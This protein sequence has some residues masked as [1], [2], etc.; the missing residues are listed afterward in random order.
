MLLMQQ[1]FLLPFIKAA[2]S[3][4]YTLLMLVFLSFA[5]AGCLSSKDRLY[6]KLSKEDSSNIKYKGHYKIGQEYKVKGNTYTPEKN[7]K[8][9]EVGIASWYGS[10]NGLHGK[11]TANGD[12]YNKY[13][14]SAAHPTLPL[15]CL[16]KV[17]NLKNNKSLIVMVNDRGPFS[18][19]RILDVSEQA[20]NILGFKT[21]GTTKVRVRYLDKETKEFYK[22]INLKPKTG[23]KARSKV[24]NAKCS[25]NCHVKLINLKHNLQVTPQQA[26]K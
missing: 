10:K 25:V 9:D 14:L 2:S 21:A 20:A 23:A 8:Y 15:P 4:V 22:N 18:K 6:K 3:R 12:K 26:K 24:K 5:L 19:K 11:K 13:V 16:V 17:T 7:I 1:L